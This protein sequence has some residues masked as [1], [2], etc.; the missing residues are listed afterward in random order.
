MPRRIG[1]KPMLS[2]RILHEARP[3]RRRMAGGTSRPIYDANDTST[4]R[5][6]KVRWINQLTLFQRLSRAKTTSAESQR[7]RPG[8]AGWSRGGLGASP[9]LPAGAVFARPARREA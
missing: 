1:M 3:R 6:S 7:E 5:M 9:T 2:N 8:L 4:T